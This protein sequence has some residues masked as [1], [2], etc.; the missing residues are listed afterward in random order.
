[1]RQHIDSCFHYSVKPQSSKMKEVSS[2]D[3]QER[4]AKK[5]VLF[6]VV[7]ITLVVIIVA[8]ALGVMA[9]I[10]HKEVEGK[11]KIQVFVQKAG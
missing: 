4:S 1:M 2:E 11:V 10:P 6:I 7:I 8:I 3:I 9:I 5:I